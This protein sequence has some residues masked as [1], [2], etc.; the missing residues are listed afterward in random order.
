MVLL[1]HT[2]VIFLMKSV[3]VLSNDVPLVWTTSWNQT[4]GTGSPF[5]D[6]QG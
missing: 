4:Y 2:E 6:H 1:N 3:S 5:F